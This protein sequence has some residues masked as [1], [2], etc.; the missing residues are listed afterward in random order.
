MSTGDSPFAAAGSRRYRLALTALFFAAIATFA[1][2]YSPQG[3]LPD[4]A[5]QFDKSA[6]AASLAVGSTT[7][8]LAVGMLP[9]ARL[10]D[11]I[12]RVRAMRIAIVLAVAVG[13]VSPFVPGFEWFIAVRFLEGI[14]LAGLPAIGVTALSETVRPLALGGAVGAFVAGNTIGG[15]SGRLV[16]TSIGEAF[17]WSFGMFGVAAM[18]GIAAIIFLVLMPPTAVRPAPGLPMFRATLANL[19]SPAVMSMVAQGFLLMGGFVACYN[20]LSFR[21]QHAPFD[22]TLTQASWLFITYLC[23]TFSS[24]LVWRVAA[25]IPPV[26]ALLVSIGVMLTGL[27]ITLLPSLIGILAGL[28]LF[29]T[30][31]FGAHS[32]ALGLVAKRA[33]P[34]GRSLAPSLYN[35]GYYAGSSL[36]G[37]AGGVFFAEWGWAGTA[38]MIGISVV[39]AATAA[40]VDALRRGGFRA[41]DAPRPGPG[42]GPETSPPG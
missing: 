12:G 39:L 22:L 42:S 21:L 35:L 32:I 5:A 11:R 16:G 36:L 20:Y 40:T 25:R 13:L 27:G 31:F 15:L 24:S 37:W 19:R 29:T 26:S 33:A 2:V 18:A 17:G 4:I 34:D 14:L 1:Q 28:V 10:S 8:G 38:G 3:L 9:W 23:G 6:S 30:G 7:I 41:V